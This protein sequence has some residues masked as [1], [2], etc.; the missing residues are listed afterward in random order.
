MAGESDGHVQKLVASFHTLLDEA[1]IVAIASDYNLEDSSTYDAAHL[2]LQGLAQT[3][4]SDEATG[5]N[6]SGI[7]VL[8]DGEVDKIIYEP[9]STSSSC[10]TSLSHCTD[11]SSTDTSSAP[12]SSAGLPR[13]T[14]FDDD[15]DESKVLLLQSMFSDLKPYTI[16]YSVRKA[17]GNFQAALDDLLNVQYLRSTGQELKGV[18]GFFTPDDSAPSRTKRRK[19]A[20]KRLTP[21]SDL[22]RDC[23]PSPRID[24][25]DQDEIEYIAER[26]GIRSGE[27]CEAY[28]KTG[29]SK[30]ATVVELL[31]QYISHGIEAQ[32]EAGR[33]QA[34][35]LTRKYR[36][37]PDAYM[38]TIVHVTG[39]VS[40]FADDL[41]ALLNKHFSDLPKRQKLDLT[42]RLSPLPPEDIEDGWIL[43]SG[44][45]A[46]KQLT[47]KPASMNFEEAVQIANRHHQ[48]RMDSIA[49]AAQLRRRGASSPL[50]RQAAGFYT[51][52]AREQARQAQKSTSVAADLL[53]ETQSTAGSIDLHGVLV[54]DGVRIA[55]QRTQDWWH[56]LGDSRPRKAKEHGFTV[57]T[58]LGRHSAGGVSQLR[59]AVAAALLQD[60]WKFHVESGR[61]VVYGHR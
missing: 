19:R 26:F 54:H 34:R 32:D 51:D 12:E 1:L 57:I 15:S 5:F 6:P 30:G 43:K 17:N 40:Q 47:H 35:E 23:S 41:A 48:A 59:Q 38:S 22:S 58:G 61:F 36:H 14:T 31:D 55:L 4:R 7:P 39:S 29:Q 13:V 3:V 46:T 16:T 33:Q 27:V 28:Y 60:G 11:P 37:V 53:V 18:D 24:S 10:L 8:V 9:A 56:D 42:H 52:R 50:Y 45:D 21:S 44:R 20:K 49:S 2:T 25:N